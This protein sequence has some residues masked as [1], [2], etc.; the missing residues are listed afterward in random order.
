MYNLLRNLLAPV[1]PMNKSLDEA[2]STLKAHYEPKPL[3][4]AERFH[5]H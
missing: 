2:V 3:V 4:I 5:F 1:A